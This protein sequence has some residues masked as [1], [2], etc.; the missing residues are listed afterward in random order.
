[1]FDKSSSEVMDDEQ[2]FPTR[3]EYETFVQEQAEEV[4]SEIAANHDISELDA[5][6]DLS[7]VLPHPSSVMCDTGEWDNDWWL[8]AVQMYSEQDDLSYLEEGE[9]I[10]GRDREDTHRWWLVRTNSQ[11]LMALDIVDEVETL[12]R[13]ALESKQLLEN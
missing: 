9:P 7:H 2:H 6:D 4:A 10:V 5:D 3:E 12:F 11:R 13:D 1:M 8:A